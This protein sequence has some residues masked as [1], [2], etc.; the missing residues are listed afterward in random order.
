MTEQPI[1]TA[2][3]ISPGAAKLRE[4]YYEQFA[5]QSDLMD[6]LAEHLI[7]L[8]LAI[9]GLYAAVL[10][11]VHG[12]DATVAIDGWIYAAFGCWFAALALTLVSLIPREWKVDPTVLKSDPASASPV[13]GLQ[14][15][16]IKSARHKRR[17][18]I[19]AMF[20]FWAGIICAAIAIF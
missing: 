15:F 10:K 14:D 16:F 13:M 5:T 19:P 17:L 1:P 20:L 3:P 2:R 18:L 9:P 6:K 8:E 4:K 7:K 12:Q 11:L